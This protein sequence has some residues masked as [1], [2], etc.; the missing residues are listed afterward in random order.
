MST[1]FD[2][3]SLYYSTVGNMYVCRYAHDFLDD[4]DGEDEFG[5]W[6]EWRKD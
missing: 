4:E 5:K 1:Y 3:I 2:D 6:K